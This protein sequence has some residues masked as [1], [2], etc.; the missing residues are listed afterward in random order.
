VVRGVSF[1]E[2]AVVVE[3]GLR[4]ARLECPLC[5][6]STRSRYDTRTVSEVPRFS[7]TTTPDKVESERWHWQCLE[8]TASLAVSFGMRPCGW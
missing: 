7:R 5:S 8:S 2:D 4:R 1:G 6:F 3:V